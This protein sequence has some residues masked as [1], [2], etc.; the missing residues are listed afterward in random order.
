MDRC[1]N[2]F[3]FCN[4]FRDAVGS[5]CRNISEEFERK[6]SGDIVQFF[7][8]ALA[9]LAQVQDHLEECLVRQLIDRKRFESLWDLSEH[10]KAV[11]IRFKAVHER[12][13]V[14]EQRKQAKRRR[15]TD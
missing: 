11:A 8:Y 15:Q 12:R 13:L 2:D 9:S 5:V 1:R 7:R 6:G 3:R 14:E 4:S 10:A